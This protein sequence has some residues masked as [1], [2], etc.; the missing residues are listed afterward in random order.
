MP[1]AGGDLR[2]VT[3]VDRGKATSR[4]GWGA[5]EAATLHTLAKRHTEP[6]NSK[7]TDDIQVVS[8]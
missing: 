4:E 7:C 6:F 5:V 2:I 1:V 8:N 3:H